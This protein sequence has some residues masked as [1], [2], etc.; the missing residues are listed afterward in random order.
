MG[1]V[2]WLT[3]L[4]T[5]NFGSGLI[6]AVVGGIFSL[7]G[8]RVQSTKSLEAAREE[9]QALLQQEAASRVVDAMFEIKRL[10]RDLPPPGSDH[11]PW[12]VWSR[13]REGHLDRARSAA[14]VLPDPFKGRVVEALRDI[15]AA[16]NP[17]RWER[18]DLR[19]ES[20]AFADDARTCMEY[21]LD[22]QPCPAPGR[23]VDIFRMN[24]ERDRIEQEANEAEEALQLEAETISEPDL[25]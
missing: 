8:A 5:S 4:V 15:A 3:D 24:R 13:E 21:F 12:V 18:Y 7:V 25:G 9:R 16:E 6:G 23:M 2:D 19:E 17:S 14:F 1:D 22:R 11:G 20:R 10:L